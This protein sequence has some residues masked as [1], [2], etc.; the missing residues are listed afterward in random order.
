MTA[1]TAAGRKKA[2]R[3]MSMPLRSDAALHA[4]DSQKQSLPL[5]LDCDMHTWST[6][7]RLMLSSLVHVR[8]TFTLPEIR[9]MG[10]QKRKD[11]R[12]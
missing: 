9:N 11:D 12:K 5:P 4:L 6:M 2:D 1:A 10:K 7:K 3:L 8:I